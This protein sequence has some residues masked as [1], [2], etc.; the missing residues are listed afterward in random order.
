MDQLTRLVPIFFY[1]VGRG[2]WNRMSF[3]LCCLPDQF[4]IYLRNLCICLSPHPFFPCQGGI[5]VGQTKHSSCWRGSWPCLP[6]PNAAVMPTAD[7]SC[8]YTVYSSLLS[9]LVVV[10]PCLDETA[11][12]ALVFRERDSVWEGRRKSTQRHVQKCLIQLAVDAGF[13][14]MDIRVCCIALYCGLCDFQ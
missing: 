8:M 5:Q 7:V 12:A 1:S 4:C 6:L 9:R 2:L 10:F 13:W 14:R 11:S 3:L